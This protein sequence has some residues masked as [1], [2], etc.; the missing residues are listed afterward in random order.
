MTVWTQSD[1]GRPAKLTRDAVVACAVDLADREGLDA[2]SV[3]RVAAELAARPMSLYSFFKRKDDLVDLM[4]DRVLGEMLVPGALP[5]DWRAALKAVLH[6]QIEVGRRH[7]WVMGVF[8]AR[9]PIGPNAARHADQS[10][11]A[12]AGLG[13]PPQRTLRL[14]RA[15]DTYLWGFVT[16][17]AQEFAT[18]QRDSLTEEEWKATTD[19]YFADLV[20]TGDLP[21]LAEAG[22]PGLLRGGIEEWIANFDEGLDWL[23]DGFAASL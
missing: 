21:R 11:Q 3:R 1:P 2:V 20:A 17:G 14:L 10:L 7:M 6:R 12:V 13:L 16:L 19:A 9:A 23:L 8:G 22:R 5:E 18:R 15:V 4:V